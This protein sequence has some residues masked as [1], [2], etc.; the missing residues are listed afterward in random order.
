MPIGTSL[1]VTLP[2]QGGNTD[3]W[4]TDLNT[5]LQ[6]IINAVEAQVPSTA[7]DFSTTLDVNEQGIENADYLEFVPG[8]SAGGG[9]RSIYLNTSGEY[10]FVDG[11]GNSIQITSNGTL[12]FGSVGGIGDSGGDYGTTGI[13]VDWNGAQYDFHDAASTYAPIRVGDVKLSNSSYFVTLDAP[14][15]SASYSFTVPA[16]APAAAAFLQMDTS[17]NVTASNTMAQELIVNAD[18]DCSGDVKH[19]SK[20]LTLHA[21]AGEESSRGGDFTNDR[22]NASAAFQ[23]LRIAI[24]LHVGDQIT[25]IRVHYVGLIT[26]NKTLVFERYNIGTASVSTVWSAVSALGGTLTS[27]VTGTAYTVDADDF[28]WFS[29]TSGGSSD[30]VYGIQVTYNR[31]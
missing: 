30:Q 23:N 28:L 12:N 20:V 29:Y 17:G 31:P 5:E 8:G 7:I 24:P 9:S 2:T 26:Q 27:N 16:S 13:E 4:G 19:G 18:I 14:S 21:S 1:S 22:W 10:I 6:K 11:A 3:T 25:N 15:L